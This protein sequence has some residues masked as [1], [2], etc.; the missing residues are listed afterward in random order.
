MRTNTSLTIYNAYT[1][2]TTRALKYQRSVISACLWE[3]RKAA[4]RAASGD[5]AN[6]QAA[7][8]IPFSVGANH[9]APIAWLAAKTGKWTLAV[10]DY[11][12]KGA[13]TDEITTS[14]SFT[15]SNLKAKYD[16]VLSITSVDEM[17]MGR[18]NLRHWEVGAK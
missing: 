11:V 3:N 10:G 14:P 16:N 8:Y 2:A 17:D 5:I 15:I 13:V 12:V 9:L 4:N 18:P 1:D 6:D 7:I